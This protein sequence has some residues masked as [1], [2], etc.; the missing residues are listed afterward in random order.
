MRTNLKSFHS[1]AR[2]PYG[3]ET[4]DRTAACA[5]N[6][7]YF[8]FQPVYCVC[9]SNLLCKHKM[10]FKL[11]V[12]HSGCVVGSPLSQFLRALCRCTLY[13]PNTVWPLFD[14]QNSHFHRRMHLRQS[15]LLIAYCISHFWMAV[16]V[17]CAYRAYGGAKRESDCYSG[18]WFVMCRVIFNFALFTYLW[19]RFVAN[20]LLIWL[21]KWMQYF[22][23]LVR[24]YYSRTSLIAAQQ[25]R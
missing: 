25:Q 5:P 16:R 10:R 18:L 15:V 23:C 2:E 20:G 1:F 17:R 7:E 3:A 9:V 21:L 24:R 13:V 4:T 22:F 14:A 19:P 12:R 8:K 6:I 11:D